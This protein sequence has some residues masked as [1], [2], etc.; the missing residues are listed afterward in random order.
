[1][2]FAWMPAQGPALE[3][4]ES[5]K[6]EQAPPVQENWSFRF[7]Q[8]ASVSPPEVLATCWSEVKD[9]IALSTLVGSPLTVTTN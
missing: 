1:M 3:D 6:A 9:V 5:A 4:G 7:T 8:P 2:V